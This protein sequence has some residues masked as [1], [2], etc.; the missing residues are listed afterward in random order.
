LA[1][2]EM[3]LS[4]LHNAEDDSTLSSHAQTP[5]HEFRLQ[6]SGSFRLRQG[7]MLSSSCKRVAI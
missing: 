6:A 7:H 5:G 1:G 2:V 3:L 4:G